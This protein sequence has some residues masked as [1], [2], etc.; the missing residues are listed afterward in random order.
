MISYTV[1]SA[2]LL[3]VCLLFSH[4]LSSDNAEREQKILSGIDDLLPQTQCQQCGFSGCKPYADAIS[5][6]AAPI[7]RCPPGGLAVANAIADLI[8]AER[9]GVIEPVNPVHGNDQ[10]EQ[11]P[12]QPDAGICRLRQYRP[13][14]DCNPR[15]RSTVRADRPDAPV[16]RGSTAVRRHVHGVPRT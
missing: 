12:D 8:G 10:P 1:V 7:N 11:S 4:H 9:V 5:K 6:N 3:L 16:E 14:G 15:W 13:A 2:V